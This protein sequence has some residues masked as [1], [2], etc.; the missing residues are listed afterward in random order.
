LKQLRRPE[1]PPLKRISD[2]Q[3]YMQHPDFR[4]KIMEVYTTQHADTPKNQR[5]T[6]QCQIARTLLEEEGE[7]VKTRIREEA[8]AEHRALLE[9]HNNEAEGLPSVDEEERER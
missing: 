4:Q 8:T 7:D 2:H 3:F 1:G 6:V 5:L 9:Q